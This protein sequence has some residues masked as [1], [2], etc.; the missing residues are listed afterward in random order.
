[1]AAGQAPPAAPP[2]GLRHFLRDDD[3]APSEQ[4]EVLALA[5]AMKADRFGR[6]PLAGPR[7]VAVIF[8]KPSLRTRLSFSVGIAELGGHAL[9]IDAQAT[10]LGRGESIEDVGRVLGRQVSAIVW[11]TFGQ[12]RIEALAAVS[13]VPVVNG[14]TDQFHPCQVLA[15]LMTVSEAFGALA[16]RTLAF[17]GDGSGNM[18]RSYL[19]GG[20]TAGLHVKIAAPEPFWPD[21]ELLAAAAAIA[22][23]TGGSVAASGDPAD[24]CKGA[25]V[26]ATDVWTSMGQ[27]GE[28]AA[29]TAAMGAFR[30]DEG[31]LGL[32]APGCRV[33]H[34]LPAHRG[35]EISAAV[36]D[37]PASLAWDEAE[38]RLHAQK[39]LLAWL[40]G[41]RR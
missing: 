3:L 22:G 23:R 5:A 35:A 38:N 27:E 1:M 13:P 32:A 6:Q 11:R 31:K 18:A 29:R 30:L 33:L 4:A 19:L 34:C 2:R 8:D 40:L 24:A 28:E 39:A 10:H 16:G 41:W 25:D 9:V 7:S 20:A 15:D 21:Q 17:L 14:L 26:L 36:L 37:G 12:D